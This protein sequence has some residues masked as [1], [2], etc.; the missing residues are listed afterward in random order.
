MEAPPVPPNDL[1]RV[2]SLR[3]LGLLDTE[4][5]ERFDRVTRIACRL[6]GV[7]T[8]LVNLVDVD[9]QWAKSWQGIAPSWSTGA[10]APV[11]ID[12]PRELSFCAHAVVSRDVLEIDDVATDERFA[13]SPLV[14]GDPPVRFYAGCP[15]ASPDGA[16]IGTLCLL[17]E[18]PRALDEADRASLRDL[19]AIVEHEIA[20]STMSV[21]DELTG[22]VNRRGFVLVGSQAL[23]F[24]ERHDV[25]ALVVV[26]TVNG[27]DLVN[28]RVGRVAADEVIRMAASAMAETFRSSDVV[29]RVG[30]DQFAAVLV[31]YRG[32][33]AQVADRLRATVAAINLELERTTFGLSMTAGCARFDPRRPEFIE[34]LLHGAQARRAADRPWHREVGL[35]APRPGVS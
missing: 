8:A 12:L 9:R 17:D 6:F 30:D 35:S 2:G 27:L 18:R 13:A 24:C 19:A 22:L 26:A 31:A 25:D 20:I 34:G 32:G 10:T 16:V 11:S 7:S 5:E 21:D 33:E 23:S 14:A 3:R 4:P 28:E 15:I 29:G 1:E